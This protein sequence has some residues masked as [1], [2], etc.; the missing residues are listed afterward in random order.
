MPY[1]NRQDKVANNRQ[2]RHAWRRTGKCTSCGHQ[3]VVGRKLC[4]R[5]LIYFR[6]WCRLN[7]LTHAG[8]ERQRARDRKRSQTPKRQAYAKRIN[9][10]IVHR[11]RARLR[12]SSGSWT[13]AE[14]ETLKR[15]YNHR[16]ACCGKRKPL[17]RDHVIAI[18]DGGSNT[19]ENLQPLCGSCNP[20]KGAG[21]IAYIC[22]C[23]RRVINSQVRL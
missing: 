23:G 15:H 14:W 13:N 18:A 5:H 17:H 16:C 22:A 4:R 9:A 21:R 12:G 2:H 11:R 10:S 20:S 8:G 6:N 7:R 19:I 1:K 3:V